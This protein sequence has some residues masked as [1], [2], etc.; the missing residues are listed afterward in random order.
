MKVKIK[1]KEECLRI[2]KEKYPHI[3]SEDDLLDYLPDHIFGKEFVGEPEEDAV[4][5]AYRILEDSKAFDVWIVEE[6]FIDSVIL[7]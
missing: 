7:S 5:P 3:T 1:S 4:V 6:T 2:Q